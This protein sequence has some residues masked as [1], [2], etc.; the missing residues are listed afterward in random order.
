MFEKGS[1]IAGPWQKIRKSAR[2]KI[3]FRLVGRRRDGKKSARELPGKCQCFVVWAMYPSYA[4][5]SAVDLLEERTRTLEQRYR[6]TNMI[7]PKQSRM[8]TKFTTDPV[9]RVHRPPPHSPKPPTK[10]SFQKIH[11]QIK[12]RSNYKW[13]CTTLARSYIHRH[14]PPCPPSL[15]GTK[16]EWIRRPGHTPTLLGC[17]V[18]PSSGQRKGDGAGQQWVGLTYKEIKPFSFFSCVFRVCDYHVL[19]LSTSESVVVFVP[20][21]ASCGGSHHK[22]GP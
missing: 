14:V 11:N 6:S 1:N 21:G 19:I 18:A 7:P 22:P 16:R 17:R 13:L 3:L 5:C 10:P 15:F 2:N 4:H 12:I 20:A 9:C 8:P